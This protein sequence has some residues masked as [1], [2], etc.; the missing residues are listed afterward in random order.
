[1]GLESMQKSDSQTG[2]AGVSQRPVWWRRRRVQL[3][4]AAVAA[5]VG[6]GTY[7]A[8]GGSGP[9]TIDVHGTLRLGPLSAVDEVHSFG[10]AENGDVC[11]SGDGY[12]DIT[13]G[14]A[15]TIGGSA[16]QTLAV[17]PLSGGAEDG[18]ADV[19]GAAMGFCVFSFDATVPDGQSA[20]TVTIGHRGTQTFT[21]AQAAE[22]I[23][24]K[25]GD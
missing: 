5:V 25:L 13:A 19:G 12:D 17:A 4:A 9:G 11:I 1:M 14:A 21:P 6:T 15:V 10:T 8:V 23:Q 20:Y 16:G 7:F 18:V 2:L 22:G 24:L 3:L